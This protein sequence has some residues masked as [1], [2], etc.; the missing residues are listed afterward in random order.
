MDTE[1]G[2]LIDM[3][4]QAD[5]LV[6]GASATMNLLASAANDQQLPDVW[7]AALQRL[8]DDLERARQVQRQ[9]KGVV[10]SATPIKLSKTA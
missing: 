1:K 7:P 9:I 4:Q 5:R 3:F 10:M 2:A 6:Y 8:I